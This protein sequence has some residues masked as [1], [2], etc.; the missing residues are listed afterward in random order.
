MAIVTK[1]KLVERDLSNL[2]RY[3]A[4]S[5]GNITDVIVTHVHYWLYVGVIVGIW[6]WKGLFIAW[7]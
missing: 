2:W 7:M 1:Y 4:V 5:A 6:N 3:A